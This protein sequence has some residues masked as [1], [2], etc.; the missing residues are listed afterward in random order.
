[1]QIAPLPPNETARLA[2][3]RSLGI[4]D[5]LPQQAY[6][7]ISA[8][9]MAICKTPMAYIG[10]IDADREWLKA[11]NGLDVVEAPR[12]ITLCA[13]AILEPDR[14][15]V[16]ED[17]L[18]DPRFADNPLVTGDMGL[19]FYAG[20]PIVTSDGMA[21]GTVCVIDRARRQLDPV[22]VDALRKLSGLVSTLLEHERSRQAEAHGH[23]LERG[24]H[25]PAYAHVVGAVVVEGIGEQHLG[26]GVGEREGHLLG[27]PPRVHSHRA[28]ADAGRGNSLGA[29]REAVRQ[30]APLGLS[31]RQALRAPCRV[32]AGLGT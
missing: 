16:V 4:L 2:R 30:P 8:L 15:M 13:H 5:T 7:D 24:Q 23:T 27:G 21:V 17:T 14:V 31:E 29:Q 1:M 25:V 12:D 28:D 26:G 32:G 18:Q 20:A 22:Q 3:L 9:A 6:D 10:F 11:R 19:R